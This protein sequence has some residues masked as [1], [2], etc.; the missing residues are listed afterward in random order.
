MAFST[1]SLIGVSERVHVTLSR[2]CAPGGSG[3]RGGGGEGGGGVG[4]GGVGGGGEGGGG[5]G[6]GGSSGGGGD[7]GGSSMTQL[8]SSSVAKESKLLALGAGQPGRA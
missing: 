3:A 4:G 8:P 7:G 2:R 6:D 5:A 1:A